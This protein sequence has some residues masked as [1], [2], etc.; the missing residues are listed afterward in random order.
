MKFRL[1]FVLLLVLLPASAFAQEN[2]SVPQKFALVIGNGN[3]VNTTKLN[4]P[5]N[6]ANDMAA[7]LQGL[8][9]TVEKLLNGSLEQME[10]AVGRLKNRLG[11][12]KNSY[13]FLF[14]AGHGVQS[15]G[16]NFLIPVDANIPS[17][18]YLR[19]RTI[20]VQIMLDEL[21]DAGNELNVIVLDACRD[22]PF[23]WRRSG[24]RGLTLVGTPPANS[25]IVYATRAGSTAA[26]GTGRNGLF[27]THLL[28]NLKIPELEVTEVFRRTGA[29]VARASNEQQRPGVYNEFYGTAYLGKPPALAS[30]PVASTPLQT[31]PVP[32]PAAAPKPEPAP[33]PVAAPKP[34]PAPKP[35]AAPKETKTPKEKVVSSTTTEF[36]LGSTGPGGGKIFYYSEAGFTMA[37]TGEIC[38]YLEAAPV[39]MPTTLAWASSGYGATSVI[40]TETAIGTGRRNTALI[41]A[42]DANAPAAK[43]CKDYRGGGKT[44]WFIPS[45][46]ELNELYKNSKLVGNMKDNRYWS[47]SQ[48]NS[49]NVW[50]QYFA[51]GGQGNY[52]KANG[53]YNVRAIRAF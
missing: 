16:D 46:D 13:G 34:E 22:N 15:G 50:F 39:N 18:N 42:T 47:S 49:N 23:S 12:S 37:D 35:V 32:K 31:A 20:S 45:K 53:G 29:D 21:N 28:N 43:A 9:F 2:V 26:D 30:A 5:V 24:N 17:E 51:N 14:Y 33:K 8:G 52:L 38:H 4:N 7:T 41:L 11:M 25:I 10:S 3:Y 6:D 40:G 27:T 19:N 36:A 48:S 44:D 1:K